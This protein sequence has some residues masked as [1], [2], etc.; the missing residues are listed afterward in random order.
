MDLHTRIDQMLTE[1]R[2]ILPGVQAM[3]GFQLIVVMSEAFERL[4]DFYRDLHLAGL[5]LTAVSTALLLAPAAIHR[6]AFNGEDDSRFHTIGTRFITAALVPLAMAISV[7]ICVGAWKLTEDGVGSA[8]AGVLTLLLM[9]GAWYL[10]PLA[11]RK[12]SIS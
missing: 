3:L 11:M 5:A 12:R 4:P 7:E 8:V 10:V 1:A 9:L 2:V 6:L